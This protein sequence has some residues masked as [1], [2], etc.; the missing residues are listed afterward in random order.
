MFE[1]FKEAF[2]HQPK[3]LF[4]HLGE[5]KGQRR[6]MRLKE[7]LS[8]GGRFEADA[9]EQMVKYLAVRVGWKARLDVTDKV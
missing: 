9:G 7:G 2:A 3:K 4:V 8:N 6:Q 1:A 5:T